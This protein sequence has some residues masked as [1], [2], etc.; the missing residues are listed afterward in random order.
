MKPTPIWKISVRIA[1]ELRERVIAKA[2]SR[3]ETV[4]DIIRRAFL[5]YVGEVAEERWACDPP[6]AGAAYRVL[7]DEWSDNYTVRTILEWE[8]VE[9]P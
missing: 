6:P 1:P 3:Y 2:A 8:A 9:T 5:D 7:R 4:A